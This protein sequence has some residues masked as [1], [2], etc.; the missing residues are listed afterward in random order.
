MFGDGCFLPTNRRKRKSGIGIHGQP[1]R[2]Y[3]PRKLHKVER[4]PLDI[5]TD[6]DLS[7]RKSPA[8]PPKGFFYA[9]WCF[10]GQCYAEA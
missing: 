4:I 8:E 3:P 7:K 6:N 10:I 1:C 9:A 2:S 5:R